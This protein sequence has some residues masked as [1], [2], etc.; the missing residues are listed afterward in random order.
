MKMAR[1]SSQRDWSAIGFERLAWHVEE[2]PQKLGYDH[3]LGGR[4][5]RNHIPRPYRFCVQDVLF[6]ATVVRHAR[7]HNC[8]E[9][10]VFLTAVIPQYEPDS[11]A[12]WL[13]LFLLSEAYKCG[14]S[15]EI[16]FTEYVEGKRIP[17]ALCQLA[18]SIDSAFAPESIEQARISPQ[19]ACSLFAKLTGFSAEL[20]ERVDQLDSQG[21]LSVERVCYSVHHGVWTLNEI[22]SIVLSSPYP[23]LVL[24]GEIQPEQ[25]HLYSHV[26][27][28]ARSSLLGGFL[29]RKMAQRE[30]IDESGAAFDLEDDERNIIMEFES[31]ICAK[32]YSC[33]DEPMPVPWL[34]EEQDHLVHPND[35]IVVLIRARDAAGIKHHLANDIEVVGERAIQSIGERYYV[36]VPFDF[37]DSAILDK[38]R[39]TLINRAHSKQVGILVCPES[40]YTLDA[41]VRKRLMRSRILRE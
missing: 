9:V 5:P 36:L 13:A 22:E 37:N 30:H 25:R 1:K 14:G 26:L 20:R 40:T 2:S 11:G 35:S 6:G 34:L 15:M 28:Q 33:P 24:S 21:R 17:L 7:E 12:R 18:E 23:D 19:E 32:W 38:E 4:L 31:A 27:L 39:Q 41:E 3:A 16:R 8:L 10:D 29:D